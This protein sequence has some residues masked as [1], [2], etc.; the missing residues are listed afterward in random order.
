[1]A[2]IFGIDVLKCPRCHSKRQVISWITE[3]RTIKDILD[4]M[5]MPT[6]PPEIAKAAFVAEQTEIF[7]RVPCGYEY[8][9]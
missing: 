6:A 5:G 9:D 8:A 2:R 7:Y 3:S 1:M 4:S